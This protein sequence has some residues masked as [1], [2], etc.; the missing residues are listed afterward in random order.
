MCTLI[1]GTVRRFSTA[2]IMLDGEI[3]KG[4]IEALVMENPVK[5]IIIGRVSGVKYIDGKDEEER[6]NDYTQD[7]DHIADVNDDVSNTRDPIIEDELNRKTGA[8]R[9]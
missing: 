9:T 3:V 5:P 4:E 2:K 7:C 1:D 6:T 8:V